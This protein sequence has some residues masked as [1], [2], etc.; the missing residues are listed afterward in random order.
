MPT[1]ENTLPISERVRLVIALTEVNSHHLRGENRCAG[2]EIELA[3]A[4]EREKSEGVTSD[5]T[6]DIAALQRQL[7]ASE[8]ALRAIEFERERL[9]GELAALDAAAEEN[10]KDPQ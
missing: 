10:H 8:D 4:L 7:R 5:G 6:R 3:S 9:E 1:P 2:A